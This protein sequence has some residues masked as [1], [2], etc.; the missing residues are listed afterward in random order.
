MA[1]TNFFTDKTSAIQV[2]LTDGDDNAVFVKCAAGS[3]PSGTAGYAVGCM[4]IATDT[5]AWYS[6]TG[7]VTSC[8]F[9]INGTG[10]SGYSGTSGFSGISGY[11]GSGI[12]G[13]SGKSGYSG[14]SA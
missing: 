1:G 5:G 6:N 8:S 13:Y 2:A 14:Y 7:S 4:L 10:A 11:S 3:I 12:S 9:V